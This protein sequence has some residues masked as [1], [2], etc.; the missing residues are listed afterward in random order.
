[1]GSHWN[2]SI[3][4]HPASLR[5]QVKVYVEIVYAAQLHKALI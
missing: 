5:K 2:L 4:S 3:D 1:M